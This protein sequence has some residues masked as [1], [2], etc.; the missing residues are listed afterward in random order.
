MVQFTQM[1]N[2]ILAWRRQ[3][4]A[5]RVVTIGKKLD[6][7]YRL[8]GSL[9]PILNSE[10]QWEVDFVDRQILGLERKR[11]QLLQKIRETA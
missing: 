2:R 11:D 3:R 5:D 10:L 1:K 4:W 7:L 9:N 6:G 8:R